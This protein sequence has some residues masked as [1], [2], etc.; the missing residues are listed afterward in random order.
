MNVYPDASL[1][2]SA[3]VQEVASESAERWLRSLGVGQLATSA[4]RVTEVASGLAKKVRVGALSALDSERTFGVVTI[5]L[6]HSAM[7]LPVEQRHF[8][9]AAGF[10]L[11]SRVAL[12][13]GD[14][15]HLAIAS[16]AAAELVTLDRKMAEAGEALG[17]GTRLLA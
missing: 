12:R 1:L 11:R 14:A 8:D 2:V 4:W 17:L 7:V 6:S 16:E 5:M 3:Y 10:V 13:A 9:I 15:L